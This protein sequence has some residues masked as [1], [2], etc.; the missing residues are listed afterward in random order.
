VHF[1]IVS[2]NVW[3]LP[4]SLASDTGPRMDAIGRRLAELDADAFAFQEVWTADARA[5]LV[6]AGRRSGHIHIW[7]HPETRGGGL[8]VLSRHPIRSARFTRFALGGLPQRIHHG[9]YYGGKGV[10]QVTL[11]TPAGPICVAV[12]HFNASYGRHGVEDEYR[13]HRCAQAIDV[14]WALRNVEAPVVLGGDLNAYETDAE[15]RILLGLSGLTDVAAALDR[16]QETVLPFSP[17]RP[18]ENP[19]GPRIDYVLSRSGRTRGLQPGDIARV[20]HEEFEVEGRRATYSDHTG[21]R[22]S[23]EVDDRGAPPQPPSAEAVALA[24]DLLEEGRERA[25]VRRNA[26]RGLAMGSWLSVLAL[27]AAARSA[28]TSRRGALRAGLYAAAGLGL[29]GA[30]GLTALSEGYT[31]G[32][33]RGYDRA[34]QQLAALSGLNPI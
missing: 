29:L 25:R 31:P 5:R 24:R 34:E 1:A 6:D 28:K 11:A 21:L 13:G 7:H 18:N 17:Y 19:P 22:A 14:A 12:T 10:A 8:L 20:L 4:W 23:F 9:D 3:A 16:R 33:M 32:A 30:S 27:L 15:V 2:L 26:H